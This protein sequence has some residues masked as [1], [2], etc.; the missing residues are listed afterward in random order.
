MR[1]VESER[2]SDKL[3]TLHCEGEREDRERTEREAG[4]GK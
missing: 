2:W 3:R 1:G 4:G